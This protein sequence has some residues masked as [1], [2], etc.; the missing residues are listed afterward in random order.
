MWRSHSRAL[1]EN[2]QPHRNAWWSEEGS[3]H[4]WGTQ[5]RKAW[6][7][8]TV[9]SC[10]L[11]LFFSITVISYL[12]EATQEREG[13]CWPHLH[14]GGMAGFMTVGPRD[15]DSSHFWE[16]GSGERQRL[17][18]N[19]QVHPACLGPLPPNKS[20]FHNLTKQCS[21]LGTKGEPVGCFTWTLAGILTS[22]ILSFPAGPAIASGKEYV[23]VDTFVHFQNWVYLM[24]IWNQ[25]KKKS[26]KWTAPG[27]RVKAV[28]TR[29]NSRGSLG[30]IQDSLK[31]TESW[32]L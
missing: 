5:A 9:D 1:A 12:I 16:P 27:A 11:Y 14:R 10:R 29:Q 32:I 26:L 18:C 30:I 13:L 3:H 20:H 21:Q 15:W 24:C 8:T 6:T 22:C 7:W 31:F 28:E 4:Y 25:K 19:L 23:T 2:S 17:D